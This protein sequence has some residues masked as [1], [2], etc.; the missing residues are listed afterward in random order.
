[1]NV[2]VWSEDLGAYISSSWALRDKKSKG[3]SLDLTK[4]DIIMTEGS[5][6]YLSLKGRFIRKLTVDEYVKY[7][8]YVK[9]FIDRRNIYDERGELY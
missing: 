7:R 3:K 9:S 2:K 1:M 4:C 8:R 5:Q 6:F